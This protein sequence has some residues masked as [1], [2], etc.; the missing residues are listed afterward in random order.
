MLDFAAQLAERAQ[1][2]IPRVPVTGAARLD[3]PELLQLFSIITEALQALQQLTGGAELYMEPR[4]PQAVD[5]NDGDGWL[6]T[7]TGDTAKKEAGVWVSKGNLKG[8]PGAASTVP[9]P[10][11]AASTV[12]GPAGKSAY[13]LWLDNGNQ[14][15]LAAFFTSFHGKDG[16]DGQ[17][18]SRITASAAAP[19]GGTDGDLHFQTLGS[20]RYRTYA[21][22]A[23][24]WLVL[25]TTPET[26]DLF[27]WPATE[28][29]KVTNPANW[30]AEGG[31]TGP[32]LTGLSHPAFYPFKSQSAAV[33]SALFVTA[34]D[35]VVLRCVAF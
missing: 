11:G 20:E 24:S 5:G 9:G 17:D 4:A 25:Y 1:Q 33:P 3:G 18:G 12:P 34:A 27:G 23:G 10:A 32:A 21:N 7:L 14:G 8:T 30:D 22:T 2:V 29:T 35:N 15:S 16:Q 26:K 19:T 13:Q 31:Y 6:N 28:V